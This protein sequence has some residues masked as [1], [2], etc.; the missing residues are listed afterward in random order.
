ML[1]GSLGIAR[2]LGDDCYEEYIAA[3]KR[4]LP[5]PSVPLRYLNGM[6][7]IFL[8]TQANSGLVPTHPWYLTE[9]QEWQGSDIIRAN[10]TVNPSD[11]ACGGNASSIPN[12]NIR[13]AALRVHLRSPVT[14]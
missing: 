14:T 10:C 11:P 2:Q 6:N 8:E 1:H 12:K 7:I 13:L 9:Y 3:Y 5:V 4:S